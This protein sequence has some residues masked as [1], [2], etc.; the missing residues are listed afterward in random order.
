MQHSETHY[1]SK[2]H[3]NYRL[4]LIENSHPA[5]GMHA[6]DSNSVQPRACSRRVRTEFVSAVSG[7]DLLVHA[8]DVAAGEAVGHAGRGQVADVHGLRVR[9]VRVRAAAVAG[10]E[11][12]LRE[13]ERR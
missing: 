9:R 4:Q 13:R 11:A 10:V 7:Q 5:N 6:T 8:E 2:A 12:H 3:K 1:L